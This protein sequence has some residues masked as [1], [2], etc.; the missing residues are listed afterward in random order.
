[1]KIKGKTPPAPKGKT[2]FFPREEGDIE[3]KIVPVLNYEE[4]FKEIY[5]EI[6][7]PVKVDKN[8]NK[9]TL[10]DDPGYLEKDGKRD[11]RLSLW[12]VYACLPEVEFETVDLKNVETLDNIQ[13][14]LM[15][16]LVAGEYHYLVQ[17]IHEVI[18]P[19]EESIK[20]TIEAFAQ[21]RSQ[22]A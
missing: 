5:P 10:H 18:L 21:A 1:M 20:E 3:L 19:S 2:I 22:Q 4:R 13:K 12:L 7:P 6:K 14:E 16:V 11:V 17:Q 15:D 8:G 9:V